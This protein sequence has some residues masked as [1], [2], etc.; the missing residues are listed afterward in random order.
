MGVMYG[1]LC[2]V[3][4]AAKRGARRL[5]DSVF[6]IP[7]TEDM[8]LIVVQTAHWISGGIHK[9]LAIFSEDTVG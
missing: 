8:S 3:E 4:D 6:L 1:H 5:D 7:L 9:V 2:E